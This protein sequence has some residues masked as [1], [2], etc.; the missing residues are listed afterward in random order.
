M[1]RDSHGMSDQVMGGA[2][3][4][5]RERGLRLRPGSTARQGNDFRRHRANRSTGSGSGV[6]PSVQ[7]CKEIREGIA[8]LRYK[9]PMMFGGIWPAGILP[10]AAS[11]RTAAHRRAGRANQ[12]L[13]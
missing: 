8:S 3:E 2:P 12:S 4:K 7:G 1:S 5:A 13:H 6:R 10:A 11:G 9:Y